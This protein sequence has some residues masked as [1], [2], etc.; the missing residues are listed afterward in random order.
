MSFQ[1]IWTA[2][3][4]VVFPLIEEG[5]LA[6]VYNYDVKLADNPLTPCV[7]ITPADGSEGILDTAYNETIINYTVL[8]IDQAS[9]DRS[10]MEN[11]IRSLADAVMEKIKDMASV[12]YSNGAT[13]RMLY[14]YK[15]WW[16]DAQEPI[17]VFEL[18]IEFLA[19]EDK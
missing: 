1:A 6:A 3:Y 14:T 18:S 7:I 17:R 11:N 13:K 19:V 5:K 4:N 16:A 2:L 10:D 15:R 9:Q 12:S 8:V